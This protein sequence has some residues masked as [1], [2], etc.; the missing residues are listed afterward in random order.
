[1]ND[2]SA[3]RFHDRETCKQA[4]GRIQVAIVT[5][6]VHAGPR[7]AFPLARGLLN[8]R[9]AFVRRRHSSALPVRGPSDF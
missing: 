5:T 6:D 4:E 1:M 9:Y 2:N 3:F 8:P 7:L